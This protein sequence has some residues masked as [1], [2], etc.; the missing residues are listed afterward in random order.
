[1]KPQDFKTKAEELVK[2]LDSIQAEGEK[3]SLK[4]YMNPFPG[5]QELLIEF[6]HLVYAFDH[7]LPL[8]KLISDLPSLK[9]GSAIL[10]R[11]SFNEEKF[12]EIRYYMNFFIQYLEDYYE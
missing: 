1:M 8:N 2:Q 10:G 3:C 9:F 11:A 5:L 4:D 6:V 12:K 7:G